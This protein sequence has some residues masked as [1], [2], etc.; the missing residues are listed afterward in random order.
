[1]T[2]MAAPDISEYLL[3]SIIGLRHTPR[4]GFSEAWQVILRG[5]NKILW[6]IST[7]FPDIFH[8]F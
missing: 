6:E 8:I 3:F 4:I 1:M 5:Q 7:L 2:I